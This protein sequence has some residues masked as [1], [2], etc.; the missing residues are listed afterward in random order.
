MHV[1][2]VSPPFMPKVR[3]DVPPDDAKIGDPGGGKE[4]VCVS[5]EG[6][7]TARKRRL[8]AS[9]PPPS[10]YHSRGVPRFAESPPRS[11]LPW[12]VVLCETPQEVDSAVARIRRLTAIPSAPRTFGWDIEWLVSFKAGNGAEVDQ[13][14][15]VCYRPD[16][17]P[18]AVC[19]LLRLCLTGVTESLRELLVDPTIVKVGLNARGDAHKIRRDFNVAV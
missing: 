1:S 5:Q 19:F 3:R 18:K 7:T 6:K 13:P 11:A 16:H 2:A 8:P 9:L 14:H 17:G 4:N 15:L 10:L 12:S